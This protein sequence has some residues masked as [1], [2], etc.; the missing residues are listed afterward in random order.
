MLLEVRDLRKVFGGLVAVSSLSM[1]VEA[2]QVTGLIGPNGAGKTTVFNLISGV[3]RP[4]SGTVVFRGKDITGKSLWTAAALGIGRTF[5]QTPLFADFTALENVVA[6][7]NVHPKSSF[8]HAFANTRTYRRNEQANIGHAEKLLELMGLEEVRD[9]VAKNLPYGHQK[10]LGIARSL[11]VKPKLLMLD[12][13]L[14]GLNKDETTAVLKIMD[15]LKGE[16]ITILIIE[17]NMAILGVCDHVVA[18]NFGTKIADGSAAEVRTDPQV[19]NAYLGTDVV[20]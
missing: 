20:A 9:E 11:A 7:C 2:G 15:R 6:S 8:W 17:H 18:I 12:E 3:L 16:G 10:M 5:Q 1:D 19:I 4:N 14:S 13:P